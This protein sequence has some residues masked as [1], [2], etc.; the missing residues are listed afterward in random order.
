MAPRL[1]ILKDGIVKS[2][3]YYSKSDNTY[4]K[5]SLIK[6]IHIIIK[7]TIFNLYIIYKY[8]LLTNNFY[9]F[10]FSPL[11]VIFTYKTRVKF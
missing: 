10:T 11:I 7:D 1:P 5:T 3:N 9:I 6:I 4:Y 2:S 8:K